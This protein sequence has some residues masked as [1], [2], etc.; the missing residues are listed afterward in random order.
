MERRG[1]RSIQ[2]SALKGKSCLQQ[3]CFYKLIVLSAAA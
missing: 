3:D 1:G 2:K